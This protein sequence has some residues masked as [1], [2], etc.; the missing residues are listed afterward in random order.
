MTE[1]IRYNESI[2]QTL[3]EMMNEER[4]NIRREKNRARLTQYIRRCGLNEDLLDDIEA[5]VETNTTQKVVGEQDYLF[6]LTFNYSFKIWD[7]II[8]LKNIHKIPF[9]SLMYKAEQMFENAHFID[10]YKMKVD[11]FSL[12]QFLYISKNFPNQKN[13]DMDDFSDVDFNEK[14]G[15]RSWKQRTDEILN[16]KCDKPIREQSII[17]IITV[18]FDPDDFKFKD[19]VK[20]F[21]QF[22]K[23]FDTLFY[24][25]A[26]VV[27]VER[28]SVYLFDFTEQKSQDIISRQPKQIQNG[29]IRN[30]LKSLFDMRYSD[31]WNIARRISKAD[32]YK[33]APEESMED[34][35]KYEAINGNEIPDCIRQMIINLATDDLYDW[36]IAGF[37]LLEPKPQISGNG[38]YIKVNDIKKAN[39]NTYL[40][41][42]KHLEKAFTNFNKHQIQQMNVILNYQTTVFVVFDESVGMP[43]CNTDNPHKNMYDWIMEKNGL[44]FRFSILTPEFRQYPNNLYIEDPMNIECYMRGSQIAHCAHDEYYEKIADNIKKFSDYIKKGR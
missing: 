20:D 6:S 24:Y 17:L 37:S 26:Q 43:V 27:T 44:T 1:D 23:V 9:E 21:R 22:Q 15:P 8:Y 18:K 29:F 25:L 3:C 30:N 19:I 11:L 16:A 35:Q 2:Q 5:P 34:G 31:V 42:K 12:E 38:I 4:N 33:H 10:N 14:S 39:K 28:A 7:E 13:F 32:M 40:N 36:E 41:V